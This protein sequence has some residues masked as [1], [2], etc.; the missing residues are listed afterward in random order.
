MKFDSEAVYGDN[1]QYIM[2]KIKVYDD[3]VYTNFQGN[4]VPKENA[5][6]KCL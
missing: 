3:N 6:Y 1:D 2:T 5:S 4:K